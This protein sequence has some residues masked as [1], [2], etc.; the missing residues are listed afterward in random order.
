MSKR[1][2]TLDLLRAMITFI[3]E[4][5]QTEFAKSDFRHPPTN[6]NP[7]TAIELWEIAKLIQDDFLPIEEIIEVKGK[8]YLRLR[9]ESKD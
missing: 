6:I 4:S 8:H 2:N 9:T 1:R 5:D 3:K 7:D